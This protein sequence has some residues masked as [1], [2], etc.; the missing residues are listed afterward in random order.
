[1]AATNYI[2]YETFYYKALLYLKVL[3]SAKRIERLWDIGPRVDKIN[4]S[5]FVS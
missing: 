4:T 5:S 1:M 2:V 3:K